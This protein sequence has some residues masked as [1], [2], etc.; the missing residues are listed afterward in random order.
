MFRNDKN[1]V[2]Y[3]SEKSSKKP[4]SNLVKEAEKISADFD[5]FLNNLFGSKVISKLTKFG[6]SASTPPQNAKLSKPHP[7]SSSFQSVFEKSKHTTKSSSTELLQ[8]DKN[9]RYI[10]PQNTRY[11]EV[12]HNKEQSQSPVVKKN[13]RFI[14]SPVSVCLNQS[15]GEV[16]EEKLPGVTSGIAFWESKSA[17]E[18]TVA[19]ERTQFTSGKKSMDVT[20][21]EEIDRSCASPSLTFGDCTTSQSDVITCSLFT[22]TTS[23]FLNSYRRAMSP[24]STCDSLSSSPIP[25]PTRS[26][27]CSSVQSSPKEFRTSFT[28]LA[29]LNLS[30]KIT[31]IYN[32]P[33]LQQSSCCKVYQSSFTEDSLMPDKSGTSITPSY[34]RYGSAV[35]S[36]GWSGGTAAPLAFSTT[37]IVPDGTPMTSRNLQGQN[38]N[39][40]DIKK[41]EDFIDQVLNTLK[42]SETNRSSKSL[43]AFETN[44]A[45]K[46]VL[47]GS[48]L[49]TSSQEHCHDHLNESTKKCEIDDSKY[50][51]VLDTV[52]YFEQRNQLCD[53]IKNLS[54]DAFINPPDVQ[55]LNKSKKSDIRVISTRND[56]S[57][58]I[59]A[60]KKSETKEKC[61]TKKT[62]E[63]VITKTIRQNVPSALSRSCETTTSFENQLFHGKAFNQ[64]RSASL[65]R[66]TG[67]KENIYFEN[68]AHHQ[69]SKNL[70]AAV[71][72]VNMPSKNRSPLIIV[73]QTTVT[74]EDLSSSN[75]SS[76]AG[77]LAVPASTETNHCEMNIIDISQNLVGEHAKNNYED[78]PNLALKNENVEETKDRRFTI[79]QTV[80]WNNK[81]DVNKTK[82]FDELEANDVSAFVDCV[83]E[84][85]QET[86][87][88][89]RSSP[90]SNILPSYISAATNIIADDD[91]A[92]YSKNGEIIFCLERDNSPSP[93]ES[94]HSDFCTKFS[95][96]SELIKPVTTG[97]DNIA[98]SMQPNSSLATLAAS[99]S[100]VFSTSSTVESCFN[101]NQFAVS[102]SNV[103]KVP[104]SSIELTGSCDKIN[105]SLENSENIHIC[106]NSSSD[107]SNSCTGSSLLEKNSSGPM[108]ENKLS[109]ETS[110]SAENCA[111][112]STS[113]HFRTSLLARETIIDVPVKVHRE[114]LPEN[115]ETI[116]SSSLQDKKLIDFDKVTCEVSAE[117]F[118]TIASPSLQDLNDFDKVT[119]EES[120]KKFETIASTSLQDGKLISF[121]KVTCEESAEH[122]ETIASTF[123]EE[124]LISFDG[125]SCEESQPNVATIASTSLQ[126]SNLI[127]FDVICENTLE[128]GIILTSLQDQLIFIDN[129]MCEKSS[130]I[131]ETTASTSL[132]DN[133][134]LISFGPDFALELN[135][136]SDIKC[137]QS[138]SLMPVHPPKAV[139][140]N[141]SGTPNL[142]IAGKSGVE[143]WPGNTCYNVDNLNSSE[144]VGNKE[145]TNG[146]PVKTETSSVQNETNISHFADNVDQSC[147][148]SHKSFGN[149]VTSVSALDVTL[150]NPEVTPSILKIENT[151]TT[152]TSIIPITDALCIETSSQ[153]TSCSKL[154]FTSPSSS[155]SQLIYTKPD[156]YVFDSKS[157]SE[158]SS[159][160]MKS[161]SIDAIPVT[162]FKQQ[163]HEQ[164]QDVSIAGLYTAN[165]A[166]EKGSNIV[167]THN[168]S[169]I[170]LQ[171][172]VKSIDKLQ[173]HLAGSC[174]NSS[175][176]II[177]PKNSTPVCGS[178]ELSFTLCMNRND[179]NE[180]SK[181]DDFSTMAG[182]KQKCN[183][184][185]N[186][187]SSTIPDHTK[188]PK[189]TT[190]TMSPISSSSIPQ[191]STAMSPTSSSSIPQSST[192]MS[193]TSSSSIPQSTT[194]MSPISSTSS[195]P[196]S[197]IAMRYKFL[198]PSTVDM[199]Y[200]QSDDPK[201]LTTVVVSTEKAQS[202]ITTNIFVNDNVIDHGRR[203]IIFDKDGTNKT[204]KTG[205]S[206]D[207]TS[208]DTLLISSDVK[209][210]ENNFINSFANS[211]SFD[212][213]SFDETTD[214]RIDSSRDVVLV[215]AN[216]FAAD[217]CKVFAND[218]TTDL[219]SLNLDDDQGNMAFIDDS[220]QCDD[221]MV[222][223]HERISA[224]ERNLDMHKEDCKRKKVHFVDH[225]GFSGGNTNFSEMKTNEIIIENAQLISVEQTEVKRSY[226]TVTN[227]ERVCSPIQE[228]ISGEGSSSDELFSGE[229]IEEEQL[230]SSN[231]QDC[232]A[233]HRTSREIYDDNVKQWRKYLEANAAGRITTDAIVPKRNRGIPVLPH[234]SS[235]FNSCN[236]FESIKLK[237]T[238]LDLLIA[239]SNK[240]CENADSNVTPPVE[241]EQISNDDN[242][243]QIPTD[244]SV[245]KESGGVKKNFVLIKTLSN[246][247]SDVSTFKGGS[248]ESIFGPDN[249]VNGTWEGRK[250]LQNVSND[251][252][253][254]SVWQGRKG[255]WEGLR[256]KSY[257]SERKTK[258][259]TLEKHGPEINNK[260]KTISFVNN[261]QA[262]SVTCGHPENYKTDKLKLMKPL[263][264]NCQYAKQKPVSTAT[265]SLESDV[266]SNASIETELWGLGFQK[267]TVRDGKEWSG[268]REAEIESS[269]VDVAKETWRGRRGEWEGRRCGD[270]LQDRRSP[271]QPD[272]LLDYLHLLLTKNSAKV[273]AGESY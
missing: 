59:N 258:H 146:G 35:A 93:T 173:Q 5:D 65:Q 112:T 205:S 10:S 157:V 47:D 153:A 121:D 43:K 27:S 120:L 14:Q 49:N 78:T 33:S 100:E 230:F 216:T 164:I 260:T 22:L 149:V 243:D 183:F 159:T 97:G 241:V 57:S 130:K 247:S 168:R 193:P 128:N 220:D 71:C 163:Q 101:V 136:V 175:L 131:L 124:K 192:A 245:E 140:K 190:S 223:V 95:S 37:S 231:K 16:V 99:L 266:S 28:P 186:S 7:S 90:L 53:S 161:T 137:I 145:F 48:V 232:Q 83:K 32:I 96:Q 199:I 152:R 248:Y 19:E 24:V 110:T 21:K 72:S 178:S 36:A 256:Y 233:S 69:N 198:F 134:D 158:N 11:G 81:S 229:C 52:A 86:Y 242:I 156:G 111:I 195:I 9:N 217:D 196:Q 92:T 255:R 39:V 126:E 272:Q 8:S 141:G 132:Q 206:V 202:C 160:T 208:N 267:K 87:Y 127:C 139:L 181:V 265:E 215:A 177:N 91:N 50:A 264:N 116:A 209:N 147:M 118:E 20:Y 77:E 184:Q 67:E 54:D 191:S 273:A 219:F 252:H 122:L 251:N 224:I 18:S 169:N 125:V 254:N 80:E 234:P 197:T 250:N 270:N 44:R 103:K 172:H 79:S 85:A 179:T 148:Y 4:P 66:N 201:E 58:W 1:S 107:S 150:T 214:C 142:G 151:P 154:Q 23:P 227:I 187:F 15:T 155:K 144:T 237:P 26:L 210:N 253:F 204:F 51:N 40:P 102:D 106:L 129:S 222:K 76:Y 171:S 108:G 114:E 262:V 45:S 268:R 109:S 3:D 6:K 60:K 104:I 228:S 42:V 12:A 236:F 235:S 17:N 123:L 41:T 263:T 98:G 55:T 30:T 170:S 143:I 194:A 117:N 88:D 68:E 261:V 138:S 29:P 25:S 259:E 200:S 244:K 211:S 119:C 167:K 238:G 113:E 75:R 246:V 189:S 89:A 221:S 240:E 2:R 135:D 174:Q 46:L 133:G 63:I 62:T 70:T 226:P 115:F 207:R 203:S 218:V 188:E 82:T 257:S 165:S 166:R 176:S 84:D 162:N 212:D 13:V 239:D 61:K 105:V 56:T 74:L 73:Q 213:H 269:A 180:I 94:F 31:T 271:T 64:A 225:T 34:F 249:C 185:A 182:G 38:E